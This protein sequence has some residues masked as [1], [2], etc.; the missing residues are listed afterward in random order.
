MFQ[1]VPMQ[2]VTVAMGEVKHATRY[3]GSLA[4][5]VECLVHEDA[6][7]YYAYGLRQG[8]VK[9]LMSFDVV[10]AGMRATSKGFLGGQPVGDARMMPGMFVVDQ[11][12][13]LQYTYYSQHVGDHPAI[14]DLV[15]AGNAVISRS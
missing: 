8:G 10:K 5:S 3:C 1:K 2:V 7:P 12:G 9:E 15:A 14:E 13:I 6:A 11:N 4:P